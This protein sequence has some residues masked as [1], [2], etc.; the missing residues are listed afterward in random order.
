MVRDIAV[1]MRGSRVFTTGGAQPILEAPINVAVFTDGGGD[2]VRSRVGD[3][4]AVWLRRN[5]HITFLGLGRTT[6]STVPE[7]K[8][9][10]ARDCLRTE[11]GE[12]LSSRLNE[13]NLRDLAGHLEGR[14][15]RLESAEQVRTLLTDDPLRGSETEVPVEVGWIFGLSSLTAFLAWRVL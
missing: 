15:E 7:P 13:E 5:A 8:R 14:Y 10:G 1:Q 4:A 12:C 6:P 9:E 2:D 11:T 3:D